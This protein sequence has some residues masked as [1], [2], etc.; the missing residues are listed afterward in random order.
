[1]IRTQEKRLTFQIH[2]EKKLGREKDRYPYYSGGEPNLRKKIKKEKKKRKQENI[3]MI[4]YLEGV[5][6]QQ[7]STFS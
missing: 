4:T 1:M 3:H 6:V 5:G 2:K 7:F